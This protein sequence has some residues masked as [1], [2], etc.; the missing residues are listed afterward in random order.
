MKN[1]P[2]T[3]I[4]ELKSITEQ[5]QEIEKCQCVKPRGS[6]N[7]VRFMDMKPTDFQHGGKHGVIS[8]KEMR[9]L[10]VKR[11]SPIC[12][13]SEPEWSETIITI[14][15]GGCDTVMPTKLCSHISMIATAK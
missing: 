10:T 5:L 4:D 14:D 9:I 3:L 8:K 7:K 13:V 12:S 1:F 6:N 2:L 15:S 11:R